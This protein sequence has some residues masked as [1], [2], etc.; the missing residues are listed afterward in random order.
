MNSGTVSEKI[1]HTSHNTV[2]PYGESGTSKKEE[3][4]AMFDNISHRYDFLNSVLSLGIDKGWRKKAIRIIK[5]EKP[6]NVLDIATGTAEFAI[7]TLSA[8][9]EHITGVDISEGMLEIGRKK[10]NE[11]KL[12]GKIEL[13]KADSENLPFGDNTYDAATVAFG[14]RNFENLN[15]GLKE[16]CR[17]LKPGKKLVVLEFSKPASFPVKQ[18]YWFYFRLILPVVGR[19]FSG[20]RSAYRYLPE[21]VKYFPDGDRFLEELELAG[22]TDTNQKHL[23]FGIASVYTGTKPL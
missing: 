15:K 11:K 23:T 7:Q 22:F 18:I 5:N 16:I 1:K 17:V 9:P 21:S 19:L 4:A 10:L 13:L 12:T 8:G 2:K 3:V 20:D 14:V 6:V